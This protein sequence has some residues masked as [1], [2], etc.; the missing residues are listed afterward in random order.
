MTI[1]ILEGLEPL[2]PLDFFAVKGRIPHVKEGVSFRWMQKRALLPDTAE[3]LIQ[4]NFA[5]IALGWDQTGL[6]I[7]LAVDKPFEEA[8]YPSY[9]EGDSFELFVDT[10]DLKTT[11]F[12]TSFCH[13]FVF[14]PQAVQ[15]VRAQE[16]TYFRTEDKHKICSGDDL[17]VETTFHKNSYE[18]RLVV[19]ASVL[20][21]FDPL[22]FERLGLSYRLNRFKGPPQLLSSSVEHFLLE[23]H[24]AFWA[25]F[26][27]TK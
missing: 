7:D 13:H 14:L 8:L 1:E 26:I 2:I 18:M 25:S 5:Q 22:S 10:R 19:P 6:F 20:H 23:Q 3:G 9:R 17:Q 16:I 12:L 11:K 4:E 15:G 21:G 24:P 27:L